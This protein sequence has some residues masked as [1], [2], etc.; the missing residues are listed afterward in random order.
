LSLEEMHRVIGT[1]AGRGL[2]NVHACPLLSEE[3]T[4]QTHRVMSVYDPK[5]TRMPLFTR[6]GFLGSRK[7]RE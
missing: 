1:D 7:W 5:R 2:I 6:L 3:R 4:S